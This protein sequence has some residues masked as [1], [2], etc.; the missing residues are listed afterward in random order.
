M[1]RKT[2]RPVSM[3]IYGNSAVRLD[4]QVAPN[5]FENRIVNDVELSSLCPVAQIETDLS[6]LQAAG[7]NPHHV[8]CS[9]LLTPT[10]PV[11]LGRIAE[12]SMIQIAGDLQESENSSNN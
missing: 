8:D 6:I 10:D 9:S 4:V 12:D 11:T 7:V 3:A 2:P 5:R 1:F